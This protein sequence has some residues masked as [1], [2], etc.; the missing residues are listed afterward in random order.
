MNRSR[1]SR[2]FAAV[3]LLALIAA[4]CSSSSKSSGGS[5]PSTR[6]QTFTP[7]LPTEISR[8]A[9]ESGPDWA[10]LYQEM[11]REGDAYVGVSAQAQGVEG[12]KTILDVNVDKKTAA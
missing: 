5:T 12:G 6:V 2:L 10:Y 4:G 11:G 1:S 3:T 7:Q 8:P 9:V